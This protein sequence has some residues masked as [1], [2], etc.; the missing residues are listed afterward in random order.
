[1][2]AIVTSPPEGVLCVIDC[3]IA[4]NPDG[5]RAQMESAVVFGL[6]AALDQEI[7]LADGVI[8]QDNFDSYRALRMAECP[9]IVVKIL[10]SDAAPTGAGEPGLPPIAPA[11][12]NAIFAATGVR[13]RR[14][15]LQQAWNQR[16]AR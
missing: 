2:K 10:D 12:A 5:V 1:M 9:E 14:M 11:V 7:T 3:G 8:Q 4:V 6:S 16:G 13:L 15:P